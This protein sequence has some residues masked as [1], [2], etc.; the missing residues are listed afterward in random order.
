M[1]KFSFASELSVLAIFGVGSLVRALVQIC[2]SF[3]HTNLPIQQVSYLVLGVKLVFLP[4]KNV[5]H[6]HMIVN[7]LYLN[8]LLI[9]S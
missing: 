7:Q 4:Y 6:G 9:R 8:C 5:G 3:V 1:S 2:F